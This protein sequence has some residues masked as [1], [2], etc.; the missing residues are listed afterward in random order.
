MIVYVDDMRARFRGRIMC[1]MIAD[2][3]GELHALAQSIG[4]PRMAYQR[5]HYDIDLPRRDLAVHAGAREITWRQAGAMVKLHRH[6]A[7]MGEPAT[8]LE[9]WLALREELAEMV[10]R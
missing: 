6:G 10:N 5:D 8:A 4:I 1:H 3:E 2:D 9:R 7:P